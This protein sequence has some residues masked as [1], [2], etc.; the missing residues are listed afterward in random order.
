MTQLT[1]R[2]SPSF[3]IGSVVYEVRLGSAGRNTLKVLWLF[4]WK[5]EEMSEQRQRSPNMNS[6]G[7]FWQKLKSVG[8]LKMPQWELNKLA[9]WAGGLWQDAV[10]ITGGSTLKSRSILHRGIQKQT[11]PLNEL[12]CASASIC[13]PQNNSELREVGYLGHRNK[14]CVD[15]WS[16]SWLWSMSFSPE[17]GYS[18]CLTCQD[19]PPELV[20]SKVW[21]KKRL[22]AT[23]SFCVALADFFYH[24][25]CHRS[26]GQMST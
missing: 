19:Q 10:F 26:F 17:P 23:P 25:F 6:R 2:W 15:L 21:E 9:S 8:H 3:S 5:Q 7:V 11:H 22:K 24:S 18:W 13:V 12:P 14:H 20:F 1:R 4:V 16:S